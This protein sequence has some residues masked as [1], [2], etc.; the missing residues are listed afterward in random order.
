[1]HIFMQVAVEDES[2]LEGV[3]AG[4]FFL[5]FLAGLGPEASS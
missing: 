4:A 3:V 2:A 5:S 1:M